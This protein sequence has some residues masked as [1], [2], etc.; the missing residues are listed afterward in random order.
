MQWRSIPIVASAALATGACLEQ[1]VRTDPVR[2]DM[3]GLPVEIET[4][5]ADP[6][7]LL[8]AIERGTF[9]ERM[10][11]TEELAAATLPAP[12]EVEFVSGTA[13]PEDQLGEISELASALSGAEGVTL[14]VIGCS[15]PSGPEGLNLRISQRRAEAVATRLREL[16]VKQ[17]AIA[18]VEGRG[19]GCDVPER[20]VHVEPRWR[21]P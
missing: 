18:E 19:E 2:I 13:V 14:D 21:Q 3:P 11:L 10:G 7:E 15:D 20:V 5:F 16:G 4:E 6:L 9:A 8:E 17:A 12:I 1:E